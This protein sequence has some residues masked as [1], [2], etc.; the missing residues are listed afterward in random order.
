MLK[1][2][3]EE[4]GLR[5]TN[6]T[7]PDSIDS[8]TFCNSMDVERRLDYIFAS[9][10]FLIHEAGP[11]GILDLG[12]DHRVVRTVLIV[13]KLVKRQWEKKV[14]M[15]GWRPITNEN[16]NAD[17]YHEALDTK[18]RN[19]GCSTAENIEKVLYDA[20]TSPSARLEVAD[21]LK[22]WQSPEIRE[23]LH[24][25]RGCGNSIE[26]RKISKRISKLVRSISRKYQNEKTTTIL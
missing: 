18:M 17:N 1:Q 26:R 24:Q 16:G 20:A 3:S 8:R 13:R 19:I 4:F 23:L 11:S 9:N 25:R 7:I 21:K 5:I 14:S 22:P 2:L 15:K 12:S 10:N 6:D